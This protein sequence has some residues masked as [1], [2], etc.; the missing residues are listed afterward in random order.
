MG[1]ARHPGR[2]TARGG[3]P[4]VPAAADV[5]APPAPDRASCCRT[6]A[7]TSRPR[8]A[9]FNPLPFAL[10][11]VVM[12]VVAAGRA[13]AR[14]TS[15]SRSP[16]SSC[17]PLAVLANVVFQ[18]RMSPGGDPRPA[19]A[20]RGLRHRARELRGRR[21][22]SSRSAPRTREEAPV[23]RA[24][25][26]SCGTRTCAVGRRPRALRPG[27]RAA[28]EPRH[29]ARAAR[30]AR[31]GSR[32]GRGR[33]RRRRRGRLPAHAAGGPGAG[34]RLGA[35][36]A[37]AR[38]S[39]ATTGSRACSTRTGDAGASATTP[40]AAAPGGAARASCAASGVTVPRAGGGERTLLHDVDLDVRAGP[41]GRRR[42]PD[43]VGQ[44]DARRRCSSRLFDPTRGDGAARRRRPARR[45]ARPTS[46]RQ[47]ALVA[48]S[49]FVFEDTVRGNVTL[50][51]DGEPGAPDDDAVWAALRAGPGRRRGP[52]ACPAGSTRRSASAA[53]TCPAASGSGSRSPARWSGARG[54]SCSTTRRPRSTRAS[55]RRSCP[56]C[57][58]TARPASPT[59]L[60]VAYRMS[61]VAARRRGRAPRAAAASS[62]AARTPS[63]WRAT[64]AT[65]SWRPP[66]SRRPAR[67]AAAEDAPTRT[68]PRRSWRSRS[69]SER[70][71]GPTTGSAPGQHRSGVLATLRR[72]RAGL[73]AAAGQGWRSPLL[74][75]VLA[76]RSAGCSCRSPCSRRSTPG[77][78]PTAARTCRASRRSSAL[79]AL[80]LLLGAVL[81]GARQR[82]ALP[83]R[84]RRAARACA[85]AAFRHVHDLSV[86]TP[87]HRAARVA[88]SR[89]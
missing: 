72:G 31:C 63:C 49:T 8:P 69:M 19:A 52:R 83:R 74:L 76:A 50:A 17:C 88:W 73:A 14:P 67:A 61:S 77:S 84:A 82:A 32:A 54:C 2:T 58:A 71:A 48:Q 57:A 39:S 46:P 12:I 38:R 25:R 18:R 70:A 15:G 65:A 51:D 41:H 81:L 64:R 40:L 5:L 79:A 20:R 28:A 86:L 45:C 85:P 4:P 62:T 75:A 26:R 22:W 89:G 24:R 7:P 10:G 11:V 68:A 66:T 44:D 21:C 29:A 43:R 9:V 1:Y 13:A 87:E 78:S 59:V 33:D 55:S 3:H 35:R 42:R 37:A 60:L 36:R 56:A 16:R 34:V 30:R 23:R 53:P 80:G 27:D 47:V 6:R